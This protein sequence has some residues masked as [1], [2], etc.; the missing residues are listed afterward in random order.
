MRRTKVYFYLKPIINQTPLNW[1][2]EAVIRHEHYIVLAPDGQTVV[3]R[4]AKLKDAI[5][6]PRQFNLYRRRL[7]GPRGGKRR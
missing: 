3:E 5:D 4:P 2:G 6:F 1:G 7:K